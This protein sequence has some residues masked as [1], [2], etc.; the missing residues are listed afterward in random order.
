[1]KAKKLLTCAALIL[2]AAGSI[3]TFG[4]SD[5]TEKNIVQEPQSTEETVVTKPPVRSITLT[6]V[7]DCTFATD[8]NA[9][10]ELGFVTY[11]ERNGT[12]WFMKNVKDIFAEDDLTIV[13]FEGTLSDR[14]ERENKTFA[15]R[16]DPSY[17]DILSSSSIE[18]ANLA[19]NHSLDYGQISLDDTKMYLD[20][21]GILHCR[22]EEDVCLTQINGINV[23]LVGINYL[24]DQ[25][26][27]ELESAIAKAKNMGAELVILS[28]HWGIE[29]A[30]APNEDQIQAA[31]TAI[32]C[33]ADLVIGTH[34]HVLQGFEKYKGRYICYSL[35]NFCFGGN[36][37]PSDM[38]SAIFRQTF[39][40]DGSVLRDD[41]NTEIIPCRISSVD[42]YNDY[43][44]TPAQG[45]R[46]TAIEDK[47][48]AYTSALGDLR[49][50]FTSGM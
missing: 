37:A 46:K 33:G 3:G 18:A 48:T 41:D 17:A 24:N 34:P 35:G 31:H 16:G 8:I 21:A 36:N 13:N 5:R 11:A 22:G 14:G 49:L 39:T 29:K 7:G 4:R 12:G 2:L 25:M 50:N 45:S 9:S 1:M 19:N 40:Y 47:L 42:G 15:F 27:T 20:N 30:T 6:A 43:C 44:P 38:D 32:D 28:I 10:R 26:R 23:G